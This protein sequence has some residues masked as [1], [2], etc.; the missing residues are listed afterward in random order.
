MNKYIFFSFLF[1]ICWM[2][3]YSQ[4]IVKR[5][6]LKSKEEANFYWSSDYTLFDFTTDEPIFPILKDGQLI[7]RIH[8]ASKEDPRPYS[9]EFKI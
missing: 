9:G 8:Y 3:T 7:Y 1:F 5:N 4:N 6:P 2:H